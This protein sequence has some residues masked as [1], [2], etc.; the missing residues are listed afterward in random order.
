M[1]PLEGPK[2]FLQTNTLILTGT[3]EMAV[4]F[5]SLTPRR[6]VRQVFPGLYL[7]VESHKTIAVD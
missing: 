2:M 6:A 1:V 3:L 7:L 5:E 4:E